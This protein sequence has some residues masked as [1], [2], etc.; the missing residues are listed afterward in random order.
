ML[1]TLHLEHIDVP[2]EVHV[3]LYTGVKNA[4]KL[5]EELLAGNPEF[6]YAFIDASSVSYNSKAYGRFTG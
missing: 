1:Q 6:E 4:Y 2:H 5:R 3:A